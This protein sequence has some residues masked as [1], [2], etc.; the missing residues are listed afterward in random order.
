MT[1]LKS[2]FDWAA[3]A[4][5]L[6][7]AGASAAAGG[8]FL[9]GPEIPGALWIALSGIGALVAGAVGWMTRFHT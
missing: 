3:R 8:A 7:L 4:F 6:S 1:P 5:L 9:V 2:Q